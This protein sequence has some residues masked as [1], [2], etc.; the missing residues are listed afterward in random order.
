V[1]IAGAVAMEP[2]V[3]LLD[4]PTAGLDPRGVDEMVIAVEGLL[5]E[6]T[7][8]V[9]STHDVDFA[10]WW[11]DSV[12]VLAD[13]RLRHG[14]PPEL[15]CDAELIDVARLR[16]PIVSQVAAELGLSAL[17][18]GDIPALVAAIRQSCGVGVKQ[19]V[20]P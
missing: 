8:V 6:G 5:A 15:L 13:G 14:S 1:A 3:L 12:A 19:V 4:E 11:A 20:T 16:R 10:L 2:Q 17:E 18:I 7:T 9:I